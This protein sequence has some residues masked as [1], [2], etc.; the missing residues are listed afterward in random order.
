M[1]EGAESKPYA[2]V[3]NSDAKLTDRKIKPS[4]MAI[5]PDQ[6]VYVRGLSNP[7]NI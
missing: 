3:R 2:I 6:C 1:S 5:S 4:E 7:P